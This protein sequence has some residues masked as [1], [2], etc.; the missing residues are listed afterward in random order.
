MRKGRAQQKIHISI[1]IDCYRIVKSE[2]TFKV[3]E[4]SHRIEQNRIESNQICINK[5]YLLI[6]SLI[7][8]F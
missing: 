8:F 5:V 3:I 2:L 6:L 4:K 1:R 7:V